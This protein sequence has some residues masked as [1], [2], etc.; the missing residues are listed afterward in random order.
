MKANQFSVPSLSRRR[1]HQ[2][3]VD[4]VISTEDSRFFVAL[5]IFLLT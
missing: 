3:P 2:Q 4:L 1:P 5:E